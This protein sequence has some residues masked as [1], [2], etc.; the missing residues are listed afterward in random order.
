V[1]FTVGFYVINLIWIKGESRSTILKSKT[2][3]EPI[4]L[5]NI[6]ILF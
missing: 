3:I 2:L 1:V 6:V 4:E 5:T